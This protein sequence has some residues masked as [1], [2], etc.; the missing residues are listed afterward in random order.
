METYDFEWKVVNSTT[1]RKAVIR[2]IR[3][4]FEVELVERSE[5]GDSFEYLVF[6]EL[7]AARLEVILWLS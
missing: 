6:E 7:L 2:E 5:D 1:A 3:D 4:G